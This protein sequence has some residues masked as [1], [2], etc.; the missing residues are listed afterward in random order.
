VYGLGGHG[1][2]IRRITVH[3]LARTK[4]YLF[5]SA[6]RLAP[7][8]HPASYAMGLGIKQLGLEADNSPFADVKNEWICISDPPILLLAYTGQH[9]SFPYDI[10]Y[11]A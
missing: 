11:A 3:F 1:A 5:T 6:S 2:V 10:I 8:T 9:Y 7:G 4:V